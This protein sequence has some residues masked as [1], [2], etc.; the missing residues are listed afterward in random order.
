[1]NTRR[2]ITRAL[3]FIRGI[4]PNNSEENRNRIELTTTRFGVNL[5]MDAKSQKKVS[6]SLT[7]LMYSKENEA[8]FI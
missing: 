6:N 7:F 1:M 8:L 2:M 3:D 5:E 4:R